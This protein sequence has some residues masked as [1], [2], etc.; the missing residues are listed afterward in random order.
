M[1]FISGK[2]RFSAP[3]PEVW[4]Y[5]TNPENFPDWIDGYV[6]GTVTTTHSTGLNSHFEWYGRIGP[7]KTKSSERVVE[8]QENKRVAYEGTYSCIRFKSFMELRES[9]NGSSQLEIGIH[10]K[11]PLLLGGRLLDTLFFES[12]FQR[13]GDRSLQNLR[14]IFGGGD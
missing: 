4:E 5:I 3:P 1:G 11:F 13:Y 6:D 2:A 7:I 9:E 14:F 10:Y 8:W 12:F